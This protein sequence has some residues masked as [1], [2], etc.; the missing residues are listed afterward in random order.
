MLPKRKNNFNCELC[1][2][3]AVWPIPGGLPGFSEAT[4]KST[5]PQAPSISRVFFG[6]AVTTTNFA[7]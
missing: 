6:I 5:R 2:V 7:Q 3:A 4:D 1:S